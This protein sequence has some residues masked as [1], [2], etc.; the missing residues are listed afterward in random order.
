MGYCRLSCTAGFVVEAFKQEKNE[1]KEKREE[2][3]TRNKQETNT[4]G[5]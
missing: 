3:T 1:A 5:L 2:K 4:G